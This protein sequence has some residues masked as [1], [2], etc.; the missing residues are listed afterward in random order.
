MS[1]VTLDTEKVRWGVPIPPAEA[2]NEAN[3]RCIE[4]PLGLEL[5]GLDQPGWVLDAG[6]AL[7]PAINLFPKEMAPIAHL[8]HLTMD[9]GHEQVKPRGRQGSY[10]SADL[11]DLSIFADRAF[12]RVVCIS[13]LEHVGFDNEQYGGTTEHDPASVH[14]AIN[15]LW[16]VTKERL[17]VTVPVHFSAAENDRWRYFSPRQLSECFGGRG[18]LTIR[19]Y[20]KC[21]AGWFGGSCD[22]YPADN[23]APTKPQQIACLTLT[24]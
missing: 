3:E 4:L 5:A 8:M 9:I 22:P 11:R 20:A 1:L 6:C 14:R 17:L 16:R 12:D 23:V 19:Y 24:R 15:E 7:L 13:T 21:D 18:V 2:L 10:V